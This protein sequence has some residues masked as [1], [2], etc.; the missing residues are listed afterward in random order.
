M[1]QAVADYVWAVHTAYLRQARLFPPAVQGRL[2]LLAAGHFWVAA[3]GARHL[4]LLATA[5]ALA[6][7]S[8]QEAALQG[9]APPLGWTVR[10]YDPVV[11]P[12]VGLLAEAGGPAVEEVRRLLGVRTTLYHLTLKPPFE[13]AEHNA[14][15]TGTGLAHGHAAESR[16]FESLREAAP[17]RER[18]V[19]EME[20]AAAAGL[21]R[22]QALLAREIAPDDA[23]VARL[24]GQEPPDPRALRRALL[25]AVRSR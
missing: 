18:L 2:P 17:G 4:H 10:F 1:R 8:A 21:V 11:L 19:E 15:H 23:E 25:Q 9:K 5:E 7:A 3:V 6:A 22:A 12:S 24:A 13:L 14:G 20:G 16:E